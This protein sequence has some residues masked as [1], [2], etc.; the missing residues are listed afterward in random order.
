MGRALLTQTWD[1]Y[2][3][4]FPCAGEIIIPLSP[5]QSVTSVSYVDQHGAT[6]T[7][8]SANYRIVSGTLR[9]LCQFMG[10]RGRRLGMRRKRSSSGSLPDTG[11]LL[12]QCP[13]RSGRRLPRR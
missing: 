8:A 11:M 3:D 7:W 5:L 6:Q 2:L 10:W 12:R 9:S 4:E 1:M 13:N